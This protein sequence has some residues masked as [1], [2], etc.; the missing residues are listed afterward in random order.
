[1]N[2]DRLALSLGHTFRDASLLRQA[3]THRSFG[4]PNNERLEFLGDAVLDC[5]V[6]DLLFRAFPQLPEGPLSR[7]RANLVNQQALYELALGLDLG[8]YVRLGEGELKSG[9]TERPSILADALESLV[10]A[11]YL[12]AGF[13][14]A[15][16]VVSGMFE[17]RIRAI[18]PACQGK[19]AKTRLQ[20]L[21]QS[22]RQDLPEY[23]VLQA[24]G[25]AH[26]QTF[27]V[28]CLIAARNLRTTGTGASRKAAEQDAAARALEQLNA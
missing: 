14:A 11:V 8:R 3:L 22:G 17:T 4:T 16:R 23:R 18:D 12:D 26:A 5:V 21:L 28:E 10:A 7:L 15:H 1:L 25:E 19:D 27:H 2:P 13:D 9:G 24:E 6:G 20:E